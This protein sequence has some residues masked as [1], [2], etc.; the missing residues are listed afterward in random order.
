MLN[1]LFLFWREDGRIRKFSFNGFRHLVASLKSGDDGEGASGSMV[2]SPCIFPAGKT[3]LISYIS[4]NR[5]VTSN[6]R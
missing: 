4:R 6:V 1:M 5:E 2:L 3:S